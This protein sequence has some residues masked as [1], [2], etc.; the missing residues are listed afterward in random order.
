MNNKLRDKIEIFEPGKKLYGIP[1]AVALINPKNARNLGAA[2]RACSC[3]DIHQLWYTGNRIAMN[4]KHRL[5]REERM[6]GYADVEVRQ[7]DYVFDQFANVT[8]VAIELR[9][10][11][12]SLADFEHPENALYVFGPEDGSLERVTLQHCHKFVTIPTRH[13][14]NLAAAVYLT[15]Y[16]RVLKRYQAGLEALPE[17]SEIR[18]FDK[19]EIDTEIG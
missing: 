13:C 16:D 3:F 17:L 1:P 5:P 8:P 14:T 4:G 2:L 18:G 7:Y 11:S 15:L 19:F 6:K 12:E 10:G 9:P